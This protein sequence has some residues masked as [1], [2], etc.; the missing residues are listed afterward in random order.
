M[1]L[2]LSSIGARAPGGAVL[3]IGE[4]RGVMAQVGAGD[5]HGDR[6]GASVG[7]DAIGA[8]V[9]AGAREAAGVGADAG[10]H[11]AIRSNLGRAN[12]AQLESI[13][14]ASTSLRAYLHSR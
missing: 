8:A 13:R 12:Q 14:L 2:H 10:S 5:V 4:D 6:V 9:L 3:S 1:L 11:R 7:V